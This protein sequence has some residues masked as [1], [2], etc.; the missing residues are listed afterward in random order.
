MADDERVEVFSFFRPFQAK[1]D[2]LAPFKATAQYLQRYKLE[3]VEGSGEMVLVSSL[4]DGELY[5]P[6]L[7]ELP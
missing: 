2:S 5:T 4:T 7:K 1:E 6:K 3:P